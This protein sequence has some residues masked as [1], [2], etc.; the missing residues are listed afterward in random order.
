MNNPSFI[1]LYILTLFGYL[2]GLSNHAHCKDITIA[3]GNFEPYYIE[4]NESGIFTDIINKVFS[5]MPDHNPKYAWGRSNNRLWL[6]FSEGK[7]DAVSNLFDSV[8][9]EACRSDLIFRFRDIAISNKNEK[10][11]I[12]NI[13]ELKGKNIITFQG[14]KNFFGK[15]FTSVIQED[16]Y[17]EVA[18]PHWQAKILYKRQAEVSVG[19]MFIFLNSIKAENSASTTPQDFTY[20]DI[21]PAI[22]SRMGFRDHQVCKEFNRALKIIRKSGEYEQVYH[23]Y[24]KRLDF[25]L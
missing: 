20:H 8:E 24:L 18:R 3:M 19:D 17:R 1:S 6:E 10:H 12:N 15:K 9:L 23:E 25:I 2:F 4:K 21:F 5:H 22:S 7:I 14:A 11:E 13:A 16:Q